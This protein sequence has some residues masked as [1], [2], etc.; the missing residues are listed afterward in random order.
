M[1]VLYI[2]ARYTPEGIAGP[3]FTTQYLAERLVQEGDRA[4]VICRTE[5]PGVFQEV[6]EG[7]NLL[8]IGVRAPEPQLLQI[9]I[10]ALDFYRP[11]VIH[12][13]FPLSLIHI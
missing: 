9:L 8:R 4:T 2:N 13:V 6:L 11:D 10:N 12:T 3:A 7:V 1:H 5:R